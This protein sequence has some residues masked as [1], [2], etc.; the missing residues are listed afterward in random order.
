MLYMAKK[1]GTQKEHKVMAT[2]E[3]G[4]AVEKVYLFQHPGVREAV[5]LRGRAKDGMG[6]MDEEKYYEEIMK[7]IIVKPRTN[8]EYWEE[9]EN[10]PHLQEVMREASTF[11]MG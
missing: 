5:K 9:E 2:G 8:W 7:K 6:G 4:E 3:N 1:E 10:A 11:L